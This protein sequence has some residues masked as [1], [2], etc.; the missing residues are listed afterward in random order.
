MDKRKLHLYITAGVLATL[1]VGFCLAHLLIPD[2]ALSE[3]ENRALQ[4][5]PAPTLS[6]VTDGRFESDFADYWNDQFPLRQQWIYFKTGAERLLGKSESGGVFLGQEGQLFKRFTAPT[7]ETFEQSIACLAELK[8]RVGETPVYLLISPT[9]AAVYPERLPFACNSDDQDIYLDRLYREASGAGLRAVDVRKTFA[10]MRAQNVLFYATD[11]HWTGAGALAAFECYAAAANLETGET[12]Y[13]RLLVS[14]S[15][16][17]TLAATYGYPAAGEEITVVRPKDSPAVV[18]TYP[19]SGDKRFS[20]F[21]TDKL[22]THDQYALFMGGNFPTVQIRTSVK[23][24]ERL[25]ILKDSYANSVLP[26]LVAHYERITLV[27]PRYYRGDLYEL[28]ESGYF[29]E[30]LILGN[31]DTFAET[32]L[33]LFQ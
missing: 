32:D 18:V 7:E 4:T 26:M 25:L 15:F 19:D 12:E 22:A 31:A 27:D 9:A 23:N 21:D 28:I 24:G 2:K 20:L 29:D 17:G 16:V 13:E 8:K 30:I 1:M 10:K 14:D 11:H 3:R 6:T 33:S 5:L